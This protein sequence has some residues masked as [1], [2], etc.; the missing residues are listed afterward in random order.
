MIA[1]SIL[2]VVLMIRIYLDMEKFRSF[3]RCAGICVK[4]DI[5]GFCDLNLVQ[6]GSKVSRFGVLGLK[7]SK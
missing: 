1:V 2:V 5:L 6:I 7:M 4:V 3:V